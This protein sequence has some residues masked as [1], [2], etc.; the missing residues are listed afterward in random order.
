M[1]EEI[2]QHNQQDDV[3]LAAE[4]IIDPEVILPEQITTQPDEQAISDAIG[5]AVAAAIPNSEGIDV[6]QAVA[7]SIAAAEVPTN[8]NLPPAILASE[9]APARAPDDNNMLPPNLDASP[10]RPLGRVCPEGEE[11]TGRWTREEQERFIEGIERYGKEWKKV[12]ACVE[13]RTIVQVRTHAQKFQKKL[14]KIFEKNY[15]EVT[16]SD[17]NG[18]EGVGSR[19]RLKVSEGDLKRFEKLYILFSTTHGGYGKN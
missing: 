16:V 17:F 11:Q 15:G 5:E 4:E 9:P 13:T 7:A 1:S 3:L 10:T 8:N 14:A 12:A 2:P 19:N 6:D 18:V